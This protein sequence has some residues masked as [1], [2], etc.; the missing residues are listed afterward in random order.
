MVADAYGCDTDAA[1]VQTLEDNIRKRG[2]M[3]TLMSDRAQAQVGKLS[4]N[5]L[6]HY[7]IDDATSEA[8]HQHQN[9][10]KKKYGEAKGNVNK[11]M[12]RVG[13]PAYTWLLCLLYV[14]YIMN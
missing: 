10:S 3:D 14:L 9:P 4:K 12:N 11:V 8:K 1:F 6:R 13:A 5:T 7:C 2:A